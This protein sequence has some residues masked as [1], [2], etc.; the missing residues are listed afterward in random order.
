[1]AVYAAMLEHPAA[2]VDPGAKVRQPFDF[3]VASLRASGP[4]D[5]DDL[6]PLFAVEG[7]PSCAAVLQAMNQPLWGASGPD[8]WPEAPEAWITA[9]GLTARINWASRIGEAIAERTDPRAFLEGAL[10]ELAREETSFVVRGAAERWEGIAL[11]MA[12]PEFNRR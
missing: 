12:S 7:E 10:G 5:A 1:M 6:A 2:W 8:G 9:P 3:V 4:R 11:A